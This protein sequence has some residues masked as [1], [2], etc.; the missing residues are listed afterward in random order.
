MR[1]KKQT[2]RIFFLFIYLF[3]YAF[4]SSLRIAH[5]KKKLS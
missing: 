2:I 4:I 1:G 5:N 3:I